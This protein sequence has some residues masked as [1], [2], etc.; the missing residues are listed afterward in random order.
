M[1]W[2]RLG[3][4]SG[5][6]GRLGEAPDL[7]GRPSP[8]RRW[9]NRSFALDVINDGRQTDGRPRPPRAVRERLSGLEVLWLRSVR[10]S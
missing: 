3:C 8:Q 4:Q 6:T 10:R 1:R 7:A 5:V 9:R 2:G